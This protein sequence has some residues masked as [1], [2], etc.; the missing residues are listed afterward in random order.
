MEYANKIT[1][2]GTTQAT[3]TGNTN[4]ENWSWEV[5]PETAQDVLKATGWGSCV[6]DT[7]EVKENGNFTVTYTR[8]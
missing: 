8:A 5:E 7:F 3:A 6:V 4:G 2:N 1:K